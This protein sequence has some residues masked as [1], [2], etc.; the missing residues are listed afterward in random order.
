MRKLL[1]PI[2]LALALAGCAGGLP[3]L[4]LQTNVSMNG[5]LSVEAAYGVALSGERTY[6]QLCISHSVTGSCR[7]IVVSLQAADRTAIQTI[8]SARDFIRAYPTVDPTNL[9]SA[10][11][12]AVGQ[13]QSI[14]TANGVH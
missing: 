14:L 10:A 7:T 4:N 13:L 5:L 9:I 6:K 11:S 2:V 3:T 12:T 1:I 8:H